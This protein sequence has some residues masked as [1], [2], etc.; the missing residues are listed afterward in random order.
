[1]ELRRYIVALTSLLAMSAASVTAEEVGTKEQGDKRPEIVF[2]AEEIVGE[3]GPPER[4]VLSGG[5]HVEAGGVRVEAAGIVLTPKTG[6]IYA[7]GP[8]RFTDRARRTELVCESL[9][10][11][12][13]THC[14]RAKTA[15]LI[16]HPERPA[17]LEDAA[18][19]I[20]RGEVSTVV[21]EAETIT[22]E[23]LDSFVADDVSVTSCGFARPHWRL[24]A[25]SIEVEPGV[26]LRARGATLRM[27][28]V[29]VFHLPVYTFDLSEGARQPSVDLRAGASRRWGSRG[30][31]RLRF[32]ATRR[33]A[34]ACD[35]DM[36]GFSLG[37]RS[38]RGW[39]TGGLLEWKGDRAEG[40]AKASFFFEDSTSFEDDLARAT[41]N[42][43]RRAPKIEGSPLIM[44][45]SRYLTEK[46]SEPLPDATTLIG[47]AGEPRY[48]TELSTVT[49]LGR[50]WE[51]EAR[52]F[53]ASDRDVRQEYLESDAKTGLPDLSFVDFRKRTPE[54][55][56]SIYSGFRTG[57]FRT[58]TEY[59]PELRFNLP[60]CDLGGGVLLGAEARSG[61]LR[62]SY[63]E[64]VLPAASDGHEAFRARARL[65][66]SRP[67]Q[68]GPV[69]LSPYFGTDQSCYDRSLVDDDPFIQ[70][71]GLYGGAI[72]TRVF[73]NLRGGERPLRHVIEARAEYLG[74]SAPTRDP[75]EVPGFDRADDL[76]ET[77]RVR[78]SVDQ[79]WQ[80]K[81]RDRRGV[82][83]THD[84]AGL[85]L[86]AELFADSDESDLLNSGRDWAPF[87][88]A[89]FASPS[90]TFRAFSG[91]EWDK[92][93]GSVLA[94]ESG[95]ELSGS[96]GEPG[97]PETASWRAGLFLLESR[98]PG[99][100]PSSQLACVFAVAPAGRW[101]LDF[102]GSYE[103]EDYGNGPGWTDTRLGL[104]RDFH[105]W[106]L[107]FSVW[108]DPAEGDSGVSMS[109]M[110]KGYPV[111]LPPGPR[112]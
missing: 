20:E 84:L 83:R 4:A 29:P 56:L 72:S 110:P 82:S 90:P 69:S 54:S 49:Y 102:T 52:L 35:V 42:A 95:V 51:A 55:L 25:R 81:R 40:R 101:A 18:G 12:L 13:R 8:V 14:G 32:P 44:T 6:V 41:V 105:D 19:R 11:N 9:A 57:P 80:T 61:F 30:S 107:R 63:D 109:V 103:L 73:G 37:H 67:L 62:R 48:F 86:S 23:G 92:D 75:A 74:V 111:N 28:S 94:S 27:G 58:E 17:R 38:A 22:R 33:P 68:L 16:M 3:P 21:V 88:A 106:D 78:F 65:I 104:V 43:A 2:G 76:M 45:A 93:T 24:T 59:L 89:L 100:E 26:S 91:I 70:G 36:W 10:Y 71:A 15:R 5:A 108:H 53:V 79:R 112:R 87:R 97:H 46:R 60:V 50:G 7:E 31:V 1:M 98:T 34:A 77:N 64:L 85:L 96:T 39:E 66:F 99:A 47:Y